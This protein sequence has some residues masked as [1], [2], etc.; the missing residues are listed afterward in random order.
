MKIKVEKEPEAITEFNIKKF[1][2]DFQKSFDLEE[3]VMK[4]L[5]IKSSKESEETMKK[6]VYM[7]MDWGNF[8][9]LYNEINKDSM[10][11]KVY[12]CI[13]EGLTVYDP[14]TI[15]PYSEEIIFKDRLLDKKIEFL[16]MNTFNPRFEKHIEYMLANALIDYANINWQV[17]LDMR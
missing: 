16:V 5:S 12:K 11:I 14:E 1:K 2:E 8:L 3:S 7:G 17:I 4:N 6:F 15:N 9:M 10:E 13:I